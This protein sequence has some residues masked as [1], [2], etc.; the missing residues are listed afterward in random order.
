MTGAGRLT[1]A[2]QTLIADPLGGLYWP[3]E[4]LLVVADL[5]LEKGAAFAERGVPLPPYDTPDTLG[6]VEALAA[7]HRP[8]TIVALGDSFH[9]AHSHTGL[10]DSQKD[11]L[12]ALTERHRWIW[13]AGN[14]DPDAPDDLGGEAHTELD[15]GPL[16]FR[17]EPKPGLSSGEIAGHLHPAA[18]IRVRGRA[19]RRRCFA[20]ST[21]R[22]VMPALGAYAGGLN[23]LDP[24]FAFLFPCG[25]FHAWMIGTGKVYPIAPRRLAHDGGGV[26]Y[27]ELAARSA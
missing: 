8:A 10:P 21:S 25:R 15:L 27:R 18:K 9:R 14:H 24:A 12:R 2:G 17:H 13:I 11:R 16:V 3:R 5:H 7:R 19:I 26:F 1:L 4:S 20:A 6:L 23:V 22:L